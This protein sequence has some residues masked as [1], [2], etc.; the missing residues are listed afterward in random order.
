MLF[1]MPIHTSPLLAR[2]DDV[3][4]LLATLRHGSFT[5]AAAALDLEQSTISRRIAALEEELD[6]VLFERGGRAP[7]PTQAALVL[8]ESAERIEVE[9][10]RFSDLAADE[11]SSRV[12]GRVRLALTEEMAI[13]FVIP[14][15]LPRLRKQYPQLQLELITSY[16]AADLMGHEA[17]IALRFFSMK[18]GDLV[19][20][21]LG[22][23][24]ITVLCANSRRRTLRC[25][26]KDELDWITVA[27]DGVPSLETRWLEH[28]IQRPPSLVC[29]SYQ[30]QLEAIRA[31]LGVGLAPRVLLKQRKEFA[32]LPFPDL[33]FPELEL[34]LYTRKSIR[35]LPRI[36]V[37]MEALSE[38][39]STFL[40]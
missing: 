23:L 26:K 32:E 29:T 19:G 27:L 4:I 28:F 14:R 12:R 1:R 17:D 2:W 7:L 40:S 21:K 20:K 33:E 37:V 36:D 8:R 34:F 25:K 11:Q 3:R 24:P 6:V 16:H 18:R 10:G 15:V 22:K 35:R 5:K 30:V 13:F 39:L 38:E 31:G 9:I